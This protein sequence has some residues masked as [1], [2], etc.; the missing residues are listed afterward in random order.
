MISIF[1]TF[2]GMTGRTFFVANFTS[3]GGNF[4]VLALNVPGNIGRQPRGII[5]KVAFPV[6]GIP[7]LRHMH[8]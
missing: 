2:Q 6:A 1:V 7:A 3:I 4:D 8:P 5:T